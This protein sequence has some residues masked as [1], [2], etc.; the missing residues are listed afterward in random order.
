MTRVYT[1]YSWVAKQGRD[2]EFV[3]KWQQFAKWVVNQKG[4]MK[5]TRLFG[6]MSNPNHFLSVD[7]WKEEKAF[8]ILQAGREFNGQLRDLRKFLDDFSSWSLKLEAEERA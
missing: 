7:S 1:V 4:S 2:R 5:S 8:K 6:D 3:S